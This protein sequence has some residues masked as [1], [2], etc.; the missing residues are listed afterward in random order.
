ERLTRECSK[1]TDVGNPDMAAKARERVLVELGSE[2]S[3][4]CS[5][6]RFLDVTAYGMQKGTVIIRLAGVFKIPPSRLA[7]IGDGPNDIEMFGQAGSRIAM[8]QAVDE[9]RAS[10]TY[11]TASND[12]EGWSKGLEEYVLN[13]ENPQTTVESH[14]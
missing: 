4:S 12:N 8:E 5:K 13:E 3:A 14:G 11:V 7:V 2:V 10:A 9:V 6:P 1:R